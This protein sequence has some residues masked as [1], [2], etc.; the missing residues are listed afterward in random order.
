M[1]L[2]DKAGKSGISC[3]MAST[4]NDLSLC[5]MSNVE[6]TVVPSI[7][8]RSFSVSRPSETSSPS[9]CNFGEPGCVDESGRD[10]VAG[11]VVDEAFVE[12]GLAV[13][14]RW[15]RHAPERLPAGEQRRLP[16][17]TP[18]AREPADALAANAQAAARE[19][20]LLARHAHSS[21]GAEE[22]A[23]KRGPPMRSPSMEVSSWAPAS[24]TSVPWTQGGTAIVASTSNCTSTSGPSFLPSA[25]SNDDVSNCR[26][27]VGHGPRAERLYA[28]EAQPARTDHHRAPVGILDGR[29]SRRRV[30]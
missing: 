12:R 23:R 14:L 19:L 22:A 8:T 28:T 9:G 25:R 1:P 20:A 11:A 5:V 3:F 13:V 15:V 10:E 4:E 29:S 26:A 17:M 30:S 24:R 16:A 7:R 21:D 27:V 6:T 18:E 2:W